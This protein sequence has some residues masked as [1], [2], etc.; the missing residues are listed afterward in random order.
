MYSFWKM[1]HLTQSFLELFRRNNN[2]NF[3]SDGCQNGLSFLTV[4]RQPVVLCHIRKWFKYIMGNISS[5][6]LT[7]SCW[8][9][10]WSCWWHCW[11]CWRCCSWRLQGGWWSWSS[12]NGME[13]GLD[14]QLGFHWFCAIGII[15]CYPD[16]NLWGIC[17]LWENKWL[18]WVCHL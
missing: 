7:G 9:H 14:L 5:K 10:C 3:M 17:S 12:C 13:T 4:K 8:C 16:F 18:C 6:I 1:L 11:S 15:W 2:T